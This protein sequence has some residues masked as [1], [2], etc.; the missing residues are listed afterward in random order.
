M[1]LKIAKYQD[2]LQRTEKYGLLI[3][4]Q[5]MDASGKRSDY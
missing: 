5:E 1:R 3:V 2:I 4:F